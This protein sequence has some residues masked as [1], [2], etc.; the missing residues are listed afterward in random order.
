METL[1]GTISVADPTTGR[2]TATVTLTPLGGTSS[3]FNFIYYL[4]RTGEVVLVE[5]DTRSAFPALSGVV[6]TQ[7][8]PLAGFAA[9]SLN[10]SLVF[11]LEGAPTTTSTS[12]DIGLLVS[13]GMGNLV[14]GSSSTLD[15]NRG[16]GGAVTLNALLNTVVSHAYTVFPNGRTTFTATFGG[17]PPKSWVAYLAGSGFVKSNSFM[18]DS[19]S[20]GVASDVSFGELAAQ[21]SVGGFSNSSLNDSPSGFEFRVNSAAPTI[22]GSHNESGLATANGSGAFTLTVDI[23]DAMSP[24]LHPPPPGSPTTIMGTYSVAP[25]GRLTV[26]TPALACWIIT[27]SPTSTTGLPQGDFVCISTV[28]TTDSAP[29]LLEFLQGRFI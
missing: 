27:P 14:A 9:G 29:A 5:S 7:S 26:T 10:G 2:G 20:P 22:P 3:N 15:E 28:T 24:F 1:M 4:T 17:V 23:S 8:V 13:N 11:A 12:V 16:G 21:A 25:N 18:M 6:R 19:P